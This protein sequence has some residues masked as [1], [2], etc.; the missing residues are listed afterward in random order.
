MKK[1]GTTKVEWKNILF[2][3]IFLINVLIEYDTVLA[4]QTNGWLP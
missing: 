4:N 2:Q 3:N 1:K